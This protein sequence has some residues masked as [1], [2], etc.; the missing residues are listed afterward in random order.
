MRIILSRKGF[1]SGAGGVPSPII[2]G[3]PISLPIPTG[4]RS[5]TSYDQLG[6]GELVEKVTR[7]RINR[8]HLCHEDPMFAAGQCIF[9]QCGRAQSHLIRQGVT[10]GDVFLF[11]G[12]FADEAGGERHH[13]IFGFLSIE[14][15]LS[16][17]VISPL[18]DLPRVH[19]H[20]LGDW[21]INNT[22]YRGIG[23]TANS[24]ADGL[25]LTQLGGPL[26]HWI[27]PAWLRDVG[28]SFHGK[29]E[30]WA[31]SDR[32]KVVARGQEFVADIGN[33]VEPR[34]WLDQVMGMISS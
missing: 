8:S 10:I 2:N 4:H 30:R 32:L 27:V 18:E 9:G 20:T 25:R 17:A 14:S 13:R 15:I 11:F 7:G 22:I 28:L 29:T 3:R 34:R 33:Q 1:D 24:A 23:R 16:S 31:N 19:P 21:N 6:L 26:Q 12:L 5:T